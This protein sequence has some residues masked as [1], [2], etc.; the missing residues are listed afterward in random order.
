MHAGWSVLRLLLPRSGVGRIH[1]LQKIAK[2]G[3][4]KRVRGSL[5]LLRQ[6]RE[7]EIAERPGGA[8][9]RMRLAPN[10]AAMLAEVERSEQFEP[11]TCV[12]PEHGSNL[13][14]TVLAD[15]AHERV[16]RTGLAQRLKLG[17][18][19]NI[20]RALR[21][22][23]SGFKHGSVPVPSGA[24]RGPWVAMRPDIYSRSDFGSGSET[25]GVCGRP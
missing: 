3:I 24:H 8:L 21:R 20:E 1:P 19:G 12:A 11:R 9:Q 4:S 17:Q 25:P 7:P 2:F 23:E 18:A 22:R 16:E 15:L 5:Q 14:G 10:L 6:R 13:A